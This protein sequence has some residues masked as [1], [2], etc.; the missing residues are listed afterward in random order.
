MGND[1]NRD[2]A[3]T[4]SFPRRTAQLAGTDPTKAVDGTQSAQAPSASGD[5]ASD[6]YATR[7][8]PFAYFHST[9]DDLANCD[10]H[11]VSL[12]TNLAT[13]L[14][15]VATTPNFSF[16]TPNLCDDGHDGDGTLH[17]R[18]R[19]DWRCSATRT[20]AIAQAVIWSTKAHT[21]RILR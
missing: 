9:I 1:L 12:Q 5:V 7:H 18:K 11:V 6:E 21:A 3:K 8:N 14:Q 19:T 20:R 17:R 4:C 16:I 10:A 13:D 15:S 2:G